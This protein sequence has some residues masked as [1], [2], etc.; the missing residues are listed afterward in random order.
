[1]SGMVWKE[2]QKLTAAA[3][4]AVAEKYHHAFKDELATKPADREILDNL[5]SML[6]H[7]ANV[8]DAGCGPSAQMGRYLAESGFQ[9]TGIDISH[10]CAV[11]AAQYNPGMQIIHADMMH[12]PVHD[13]SYHAVIA[14]YSIIHTPKNCTTSLLSELK[15]VLRVGGILLIV[16]KKGVTEGLVSNGWFEGN[17]VHFSYFTEDELI[18]A[19]TEAGMQ[20]I[21]CETR[22]PYPDE[23]QDYRIYITACKTE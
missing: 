8:L 14:F 15:R 9:V 11:L 6:P 13:C 21:G 10:A 18:N 23:I 3:Y 19:A 2:L 4:D 16:V 7:D 17:A 1:M 20:L 22:E 5:I 12:L